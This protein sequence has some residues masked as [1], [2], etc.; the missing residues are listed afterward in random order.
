MYDATSPLDGRY[1]LSPLEQNIQENSCK[2]KI[3]TITIGNRADSNVY[4]N[5]WSYRCADRL[6]FVSFS[7]NV[8]LNQSLAKKMVNCFN[9][10][11]T[12]HI[13]FIDHHN[14]FRIGTRDRLQ[15]L[16]QVL[17]TKDGS[18]DFFFASLNCSR[19]IG[20]LFSV[21]WMFSLT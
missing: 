9:S 11:T 13:G 7:Q 15:V 17:G 5:V 16:L 8:L 21:T 10:T 1:K 4:I 18:F 3:Y 12:D 6:K 20:N 19:M 14:V 2:N